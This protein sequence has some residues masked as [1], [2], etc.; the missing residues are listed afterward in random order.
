MQ[1][2]NWDTF[3]F[4]VIYHV[5][6]LALA[7]FA[8]TDFSWAAFAV[9]FVT[10]CLGGLSIT[11]GYHRLFSHKT[12]SAHPIFETFI[13]GI[14]T[15]AFQW[16]AY[17]W[18]HD[19]RKHHNHVDTEKDPYSIK[20]G[21][22]Y[23]HVLWLFDYDRKMDH[24]LVE[25]LQKNPRVMFQH[26]HF[27]PL[28]WAINLA[29]FGLTCL[30]LHPLTAFF[31]SFVLRVFFIHH[32]TWFI[33]SLAHTWGSRTYAKELSAVD[34][35]ILAL[36]TF[37]EGYHNYH[38]AFANDY[39]NGIR[40][41]H[42]DPS[43]WIVWTASKLGLAKN[44]RKVERLRLQKI[45]VRKDKKLILEVLKEHKDR[46]AKLLSEKLTQLASTFE[47]KSALLSRKYL[48]FKRSKS[49]NTDRKLIRTE[50]RKLQSE[51]GQIWS[52]WIET[53]QRA[54]RMFELEHAH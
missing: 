19:H 38:H 50:I 39:R 52:S 32:S 7:P 46:E 48:E 18:S 35:A 10:Y 49:N 17:A 44:L 15:L 27:L 4:I 21:F 12:Y 47:E 37:G 43:K 8:F 25:D 36:L 2:K 29:V 23:A 6:L 22:W 51:L 53:T 45:L 41:W 5:L 1:I 33:N 26:K 16:S 40:W 54:G 11:V 14:S 13:L 30:F 42:F 24:D 31:Y 28:T 34:N 9:F 20:K 3:L